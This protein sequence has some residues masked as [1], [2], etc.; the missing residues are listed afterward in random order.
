MGHG[1]SES[2]GNFLQTSIGPFVLPGAA[3][4]SCHPQTL[5]GLT[6]LGARVLFNHHGAITEDFVLQYLEQHIADP[7]GVSR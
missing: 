3:R 4:V 2:R 7:T 5:L 6:V 1:V